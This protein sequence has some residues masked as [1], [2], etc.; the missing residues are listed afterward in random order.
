MTSYY[1]KLLR[2]NETVVHVGR[3]HWIVYD[4][5]IGFLV[6]GAG[7]IGAGAV[8]WPPLILAG[9]PMLLLAAGAAFM[10]WWT[11]LTT[12][13]VVTDRRVIYKK[14]WLAIDTREINLAKIE[15][16]DFRQ[17]SLDRMIGAGAAAGGTF[18][19]GN[20]IKGKCNYYGNQY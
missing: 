9:L 11:R 12:E 4:R 2:P 18:N 16:V 7:L 10:A 6:I 17:S 20:S 3:L 1:K 14:H 15:T 13:V 5:A 8:G 19:P